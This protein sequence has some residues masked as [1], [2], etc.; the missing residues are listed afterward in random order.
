MDNEV[1]LFGQLDGRGLVLLT[2]RPVDF[3]PT[4]KISNV[5]L[6]P[7]LENAVRY[8][9]VATQPIGVYPFERKADCET[10]SPAPVASSMPGRNRQRSCHRR[11]A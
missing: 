10:S 6:V 7:S 3:H 5:V 11:A 1:T 2:D 4:N 8:V 9:N